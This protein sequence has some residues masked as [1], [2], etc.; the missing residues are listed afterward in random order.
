MKAG[1]ITIR[2]LKALS[3]TLRRV[4][5]GE[6]EEGERSS[7]PRNSAYNQGLYYYVPCGSPACAFGWHLHNRGKLR[8]A[9]EDTNF[10][11]RKV[12]E[13]PGLTSQELD[14]LFGHSGC[15]DAGND[16]GQAADYIDDFIAHKLAEET[17]P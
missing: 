5:R 8:E 12:S 9:I 16:A 13:F 10:M 1:H 2:R 14:R 15:N 4:A 17:R 6:L 7:D 11:G 3:K